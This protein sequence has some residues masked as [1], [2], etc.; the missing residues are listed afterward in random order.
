M[1]TIAEELKLFVRY[2]FYTSVPH[3]HDMVNAPRT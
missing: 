2:V 3:R 1:A